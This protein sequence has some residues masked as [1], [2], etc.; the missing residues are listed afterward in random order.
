MK[1]RTLK[2]S[3]LT[4]LLSAAAAGTAFAGSWKTDAF[5]TYYENDNGTRP[6]YAKTWVCLDDGMTYAFDPDGY[7]IIDGYYG[8][9]RT[10]SSGQLVEKTEEQL[11]KEAVEKAERA[12]RPNP[13]K[14]ATEAKAAGTAA[15]Q[16]TAAATTTRLAYQAEMQTFMDRAF[17]ALRTAL[18]D[19]YPN[20]IGDTKSTS[21]DSTYFY[22]VRGDSVYTLSASKHLVSS[23]TNPDYTPYA[24]SVTYDRGRLSSDSG[25]DYFNEAFQTLVIAAVGETAGQELYDTLMADVLDGTS[26]LKLSGTTDTGN[27][28]TA[29]YVGNTVTVQVTCSEIVPETEDENAEG[30]TAEGESTEEAVEETPTTSV[31]TVGAGQSSTAETEASE[32]TTDEGTEENAEASEETSG[33]TAVEETANETEVASE[34]AAAETE[35][36][37]EETAAEETSAEEA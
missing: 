11:A 8:T 5:G 30:E 7:L 26:L 2:I 1:K 23:E 15:K 34:E 27:S 6:A 10:N 9:F 32:E 14:V 21:I 29:N 17:V 4:A 24:F 35:A 28:Y 3:A 16:L 33:E 12:S 22:R 13:S 19:D 37:A 20:L 18:G 36:A 31:I 25:L